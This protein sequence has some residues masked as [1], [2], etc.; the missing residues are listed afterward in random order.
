MKELLMVFFIGNSFL[1]NNPSKT[2]ST[3]PGR[4]TKCTAR[5]GPSEAKSYDRTR[6]S[7]QV[8]LIREKAMMLQ[9]VSCKAAASKIGCL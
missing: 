4:T 7:H 6:Y 3:V 5:H 2:Q 8:D 1:A 9:D